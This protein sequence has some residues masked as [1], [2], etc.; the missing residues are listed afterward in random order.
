MTDMPTGVAAA[1]PS[2]M[3]RETAEA[4]DVVARLLDQNA[5]ACAVL[6][7]RLRQ[8][9][10]DRVVVCPTPWMPMTAADTIPSATLDLSRP[11]WLMHSVR[12]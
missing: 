6:G 11:G 3:L 12:A 9:Q 5:P 10:T 2:L 7:D 4:P 1:T 8:G